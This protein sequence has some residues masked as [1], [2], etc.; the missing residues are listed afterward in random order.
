MI[1]TEAPPFASLQLESATPG[2]LEERRLPPELPARQRKEVMSTQATPLRLPGPPG[3]PICSQAETPP[4][5]FVDLRMR[6]SPA[7]ARQKLR[8][9]QLTPARSSEGSSWTT[10]QA[11]EGPVGLV[12]VRTLPAV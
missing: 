10:C 1:G 9:A 12:V 7:T 8:E 5:G 6:P 11:E 3:V 2:V 4:P